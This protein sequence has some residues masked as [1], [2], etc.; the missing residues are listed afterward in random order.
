MFADSATSTVLRHSMRQTAIDFF[1]SKRLS[2]EGVFTTP[3][4]IP[5][6]PPALLVCHPHPML[7]GSMDH[8]LVMAICRTAHR[9]GIAS[10]RFNFRG[11]G[12]SQG[13]FSNGQQEHKDLKSAFEILKLLPGID[14]FRLAVVGYSFGASV[15]LSGL[16]RCKAARSFVLIAPPVSSVKKS[17][18]SKDKRPKLFIAGERD[19][20]V[21][22][23][24]LQ[25]ALD[26]LRTPVQFTEIKDADHTLGEQL[27]EVADR[28]LAFLPETLPPPGP[29]LKRSRRWRLGLGGP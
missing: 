9:E 25:S 28:V 23:V 11:V 22:S 19:S 10:L 7:G 26:E 12:A 17:R 21:P 3:E 24:A 27:Q 20:V 5:K 4:G 14:P 6:P 18:I 15:V 13:T 16:T 8:P 29:D 2:L 1:T